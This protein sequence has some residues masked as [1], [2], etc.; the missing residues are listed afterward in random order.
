[1]P[2]LADRCAPRSRLMERS[3]HALFF[4]LVAALFV[5][6]TVYE[7]ANGSNTLNLYHVLLA[8]VFAFTL[9]SRPKIMVSTG[10]C[11]F[12]V[13]ATTSVLG[14]SIYGFTI[15]A[16]LLPIAFLAFAA[17][18]RWTQ[19]TTQAERRVTYQ[20]IFVVVVAAII[21]RNLLYIDSL[22]SVYARARSEA[23]IFYL[24][25]GG[26]NLE[27]T[28]L[29]ML[30]TLL[31]GT[32]A[33]VPAILVAAVTSL[34]VMSRSGILAVLVSLMLWLVHGRFGR[35]K[36]VAGSLVL[37]GAMLVCLVTIEGT[38]HIPII[39]RFDIS[40]ERSLAADD[41]GRLAM[42]G[43][44]AEILSE[45]PLGHGVGN[46]FPALNEHL[47]GHLRENNA[48]NIYVE[49]ALD[50]G[51]QSA[52]LFACIMISILRTPG[53]IWSPCHRFALSYGILGLVEYTGYD[54]IGWFFIG[55]AHASSHSLIPSERHQS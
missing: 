52:C 35:G 23:P 22:G 38:Y 15:R 11:F 33:F 31:I 55:A 21:I 2:R 7:S 14:W 30:S 12:A 17:G 49:L 37:L 46:G 44:A 25:S 5:Q 24:S 53:M 40:T 41:Q 27:A 29:G 42:W 32:V 43:A 36:F 28:Q 48:H 3:A 45:R 39:E 54:A 1:M 8:I 13:L 4:A 34:L 20:S 6:L 18:N 10:T 16:V 9:R 19:L 47:G 50:G 51:L 26:K